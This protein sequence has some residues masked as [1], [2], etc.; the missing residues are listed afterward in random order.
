MDSSKRYDGDLT[1]VTSFEFIAPNA[2]KKHVTEA[3][4][5]AYAAD[6]SNSVENIPHR[7]DDKI[8]SHYIQEENP[9]DK[10]NIPPTE[11]KEN[12]P[13]LPLHSVFQNKQKD[14]VEI[15][16][17]TP[18]PCEQSS[19][20]DASILPTDLQKGVD[21]INVLID[22]RNMDHTTKKKLI[23]KIVRHLLKSQDTKDITQMIMNYSNK[24]NTNQSSQSSSNGLND[25]KSNSNLV[26]D[27]SK[28][29][30]SGVS[31]LSSSTSTASEMTK[32]RHQQY[33]D[34]C[35]KHED[36][37]EEKDWLKPVTQSEIDKENARKSGTSKIENKQK[38]QDNISDDNQLL[39]EQCKTTPNNEVFEFLQNEKKTHFNWIDQE[40]E[41]LNNLKI[42]LQNMNL[43]ETNNSK[44]NIFEE[45]LNSVYTK[46]DKDFLVIYE[47]YRRHE[48]KNSSEDGSHADISS[49]LRGLFIFILFSIQIS[50]T[51]QML[52]I[53]RKRARNLQCI[54][55]GSD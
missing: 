25:S 18:E 44:Q 55:K 8:E 33:N 4:A 24:R 19:N 10:E 23:R 30:I 1:S 43:S 41:H 46:H 35:S 22:S 21:L 3:G 20:N 2:Y 29:G 49:A 5:S 53:L 45:K 38:Q 12:I 34:E 14:S 31:T 42:L 54:F 26:K 27:D 47:N 39:K 48:N 51:N 6:I 15:C 28:Q 52:Q 13:P 16:C 50:T 37:M 32:D 40:I 9:D 36:S 7:T 17:K 11:D